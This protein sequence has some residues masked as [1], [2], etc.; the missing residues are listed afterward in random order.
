MTGPKRRAHGRKSAQ[1]SRRPGALMRRWVADRS[2]ATA[3]EFTLLA[4]PFFLIVFAILETSL[5]FLGE[6]T[7]HQGVA[8]VSRDLRVGTIRTGQSSLFQSRLCDRVGHLLTCNKLRYDVRSYPSYADIPAP[9][10]GRDGTFD[11]SGFQFAPGGPGT[12]NIV[13]V[14]YEWPLTLDVFRRSLGGLKNGNYLLASTTAFRQE[15]Y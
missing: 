12:I 6:T 14:Y 9:T 7:L 11:S 2:G 3:V 1:T 8:S 13:R 5:V 15:S 4:L 10:A